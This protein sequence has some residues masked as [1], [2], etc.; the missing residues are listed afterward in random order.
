VTNFFTQRFDI[1]AKT[2]I[3]LDYATIVQ[4]D[5]PATVTIAPTTTVSSAGGDGVQSVFDFSTLNNQGFIISGDESSE[6][7]LMLGKNSLL[8]N[9]AGAR[10]FG[11]GEGVHMDGDGATVD[12][13]GSIESLGFDAVVFGTEASHATFTN[14]GSIFGRF[15][16]VGMF[17]A[18]DGGIIRNAGTIASADDGIV[19]ET[20]AG[21]RTVIDN[22]GLI[23]GDSTAIVVN[24]GGINL[25][26]RG[27]IAG[28]IFV[29]SSA[30]D[31][32]IIANHGRILGQ[33]ELGDGNDLFDGRGGAAEEVFGGNGDNTLIGGKRADTFFTG[34]GN[35]RLIGGAGSD[36]LEG[37]GGHDTLT[38]GAGR[39]QFRFA[40]APLANLNLERITDFTPNVDK[41][42]LDDHSF[43]GLGKDGVLASSKFHLGAAAAHAGDRI[44]YNPD[45]GFLFYDPDGKGGTDEIHFATLAPHLALH[46]SDFLVELIAI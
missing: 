3:A 10:I 44:I 1:F 32:A 37:G 2:G 15:D 18:S 4:P 35:D 25:D 31:N 26:N 19:V 24:L 34:D 12:N 16:G 5:A 43:A 22:S 41:L 42:V 38:G 29:G 20:V 39:D 36:T 17:S 8:S 45:N 6:G 21:G 7:V 46:N 40:D 9:A 11:T 23:E 13:S 27:T 14:N 30:P 33:V 28:G